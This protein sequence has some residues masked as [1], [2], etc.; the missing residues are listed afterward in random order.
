MTRRAGPEVHERLRTLNKCPLQQA[1]WCVISDYEMMKCE[2]MIMAFAA[3]NL[4]PDLNCVRGTSVQ[5]CMYK[6]Q[7]GDADL[8]T[9]DAADVYMAGKSVFIIIVIVVV[10]TRMLLQCC[11]SLK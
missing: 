5:D 4:R 1:R 8:I 11:S 7:T 10:V 9:L 6:I 2:S 3:K